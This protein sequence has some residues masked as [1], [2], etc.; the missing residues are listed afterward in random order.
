MYPQKILRKI[1]RVYLEYRKNKEF[2]HKEFSKDGSIINNPYQPNFTV[3]LKRLTTVLE[4]RNTSLEIQKLEK[5]K[6]IFRPLCKI[7]Y[8]E[9]D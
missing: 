7:N 3:R 6:F 5:G 9:I 4:N 2:Y 1:I 8:S